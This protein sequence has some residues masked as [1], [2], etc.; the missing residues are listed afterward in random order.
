[1]IELSR[2]VLRIG[3]SCSLEN[4]G[5]LPNF[6][7]THRYDVPHWV[8]V[9]TI[10]QLVPGPVSRPIGR[11][12]RVFWCSFVNVLAICTFTAVSAWAQPTITS[13]QV[14]PPNASLPVSATQH[15]T[16]VASLS[17]GTSRD[18]TAFVAWSSA[19]GNIARV[20]ASGLVTPK[21]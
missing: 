5:Q 17:D 21:K 12:M 13:I 19:N 11:T 7:S 6:R 18:V 2:N 20:D 8:A 15:Y 16:A 4:L 1:D 10:K 9:V 14:A 3:F